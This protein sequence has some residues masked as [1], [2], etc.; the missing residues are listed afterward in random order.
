MPYPAI[1]RTI[2]KRIIGTTMLKILYVRILSGLTFELIT[3]PVAYI[4]KA[5]MTP[6]IMAGTKFIGYILLGT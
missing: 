6:A 5:H 2:I 3:T 1:K 4:P